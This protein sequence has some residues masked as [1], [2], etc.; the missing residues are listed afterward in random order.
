MYI[1]VYNQVLHNKV[2]KSSEDEPF[3]TTV[4]KEELSQKSKEAQV[5]PQHHDVSEETTNEGSDCQKL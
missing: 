4:S 3:I 5:L 2:R 1:I